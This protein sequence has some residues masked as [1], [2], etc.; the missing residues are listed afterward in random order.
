MERNSKGITQLFIIWGRKV[1]YASF[2]RK[3]VENPLY[4]K[5]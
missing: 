4:P 3:N 1:R 5:S 2:D